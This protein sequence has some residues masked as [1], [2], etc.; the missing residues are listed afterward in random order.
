MPLANLLYLYCLLLWKPYLI[1]NLLTFMLSTRKD[2]Q[3][4]LNLS[5]CGGFVG[6]LA[7]RILNK[8]KLDQVLLCG[9]VHLLLFV[10]MLV[11][12]RFANLPT[13]LLFSGLAY[14]SM[15]EA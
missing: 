3:T 13:I 7:S 9:S 11:V 2:E 6:A 8:Q 5:L 1:L 15:K 12:Q 10:F 14:V 4:I